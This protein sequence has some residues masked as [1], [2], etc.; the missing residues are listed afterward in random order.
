MSYTSKDYYC[1]KV[2]FKMNEI[3]T[4]TVQS[5]KLVELGLDVNTADMRWEAESVNFRRENPIQYEERPR[6]GFLKP[7]LP[8]WSLSALFRLMPD[9]GRYT[10][11]IGRFD[12]KYFCVYMDEDGEC[13]KDFGSDDSLLDPAFEMVCWL[14]E[15]GK[16]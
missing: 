2:N 13:E 3:C 7:Y 14:K 12:G 8:A 1:F 15:N 6:V 10:P 11:Q 4:S 16:I 5:K 9:R